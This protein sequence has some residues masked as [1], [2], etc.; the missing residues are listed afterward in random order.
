VDTGTTSG[1]APGGLPVYK[2]TI[3]DMN[4]GEAFDVD[5]SWDTGS[6]I[7]SAESTWTVDALTD[8]ALTLSISVSNTSP[9][10]GLS[11]GG[12]ASIGFGI[13]PDA[14]SVA[15][16]T[17][18]AGT[19]FDSTGFAFVPGFNGEVEI[20]AWTANSCAGGGQNSLLAIGDSD[21]FTLQVGG[22][23]ADGNGGQTL[24]LDQFALKTQTNVGSFELPGAPP[25]GNPPGGGPPGNVPTPMTLALLGIGLVG[26]G[27]SRRRRK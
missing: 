12:I 6:G 13:D 27:A 3:T 16:A 9:Q 19:E 1:G 10:P 4:I 26:I 2:A 18:G 5:W 14:T 17:G 24:M 25:G 15:F 22:N 21:V 8:S 11:T 7:F 23:F 20:C